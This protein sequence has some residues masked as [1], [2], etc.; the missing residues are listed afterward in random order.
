MTG[1]IGSSNLT[2]GGLRSNV[3]VNV[4]LDFDVEAQEARALR[5][6]YTRLKFQPTRF[7][8]DDDYI[9][10]YEEAVER[11]K[12]EGQRPKPEDPLRRAVLSVREKERVLPMPV[13]PGCILAGWQKLVY[14]KLPPGEFRSSDL[15]R[16]AA[17]FCEFYPDN[18]NIE[19]KIRQVLQRLRDV[20]LVHYLGGAR[21]ENPLAALPGTGGAADSPGV[22]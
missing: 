7:A 4:A 18:K 13:R 12:A 22:T 10:A 1:I 17:E 20:G 9:S 8:P 6:I 19:A 21:W 15:Y 3:E 5:E 14:A 16:Y 11:A 2:E